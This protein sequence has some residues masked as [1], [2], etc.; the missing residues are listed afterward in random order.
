MSKM[1]SAVLSSLFLLL[2]SAPTAMAG[3]VD[4]KGIWCDNDSSSFGFWFRDDQAFQYR[5][6]GYE[7]RTSY[8][9]HD[10]TEVGAGKLKIG[11]NQMLNRKTLE[12]SQYGHLYQCH[13]VHSSDE[14]EQTLQAIIDTA[15]IENKL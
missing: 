15:K 2:L 12:L 11:G 3:A 6:E 1:T 4:G 10:Y 9:P 8:V 14:L 13:V 5:I 7:I